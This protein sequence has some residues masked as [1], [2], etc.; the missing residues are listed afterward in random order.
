MRYWRH[1]IKSIEL[2]RLYNN[3]Y[4]NSKLFTRIM[5]ELILELGEY[6]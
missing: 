5:T 6:E 2:V 3:N 1:D 4:I